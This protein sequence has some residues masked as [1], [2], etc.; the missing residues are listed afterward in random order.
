MVLGGILGAVSGSGTASAGG[1]A[2][3]AYPELCRRGYSSDLAAAT[4]ATSGCLSAIV[5]PTS[6]LIVFAIAA[7]MSVSELFMAAFIPGF[8]CIVVFCICVYVWFKRDEKKNLAKMASGETDAP[9][10][11]GEK[12]VKFNGRTV[13]VIVAGLAILLSIFVGIYSGLFTPTEAGAV[14]AFIAMIAAIVSGNFSFKYFLE[15]ISDTVKS[16]AMI[17]C[18]VV[19]ANIFA[20][21]VS[22]SRLPRMITE[23]FGPL[24][25]RP[26]LLMF[27]VLI[28]F[29]IMFMIL[30]TTAPILMFTPILMP[31][32]VAAG[33]DGIWFGILICLAG[34]VGLVTPPVGIVA[35]VV[36]G[37]LKIKSG[38]IFRIT[39]VWAA[40]CALAVGGL[41]IIFPQTALWL[42]SIL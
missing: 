29:F 22:L 18:M 40:I 10:A 28:F 38:G 12:P 33:Y 31:L 39:L 36:A 2:K 26:V 24:I 19:S 8:L 42:P 11:E 30:D 21:F 4:V 27:I 37:Q 5:P 6:V 15:A 17:M 23:A 9:E 41:L 14:G 13:F 1:L 16:T 34:T 20:R 3:C 25:E 7:E 35:Y 32:V